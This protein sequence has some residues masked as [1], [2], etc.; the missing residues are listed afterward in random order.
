MPAL[1]I[2]WLARA[3]GKINKPGASGIGALMGV[4]GMLFFGP[5]ANGE[6]CVVE[7]VLEPTVEEVDEPA[8][9]TEEDSLPN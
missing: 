9:V 2:S 7:D 8:E 5:A 4:L 6:D 1:T 3:G